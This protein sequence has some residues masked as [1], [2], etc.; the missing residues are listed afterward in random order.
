[1]RN[2]MRAIARLLGLQ[3]QPTDSHAQPTQTAG[4]VHQ[5]PI[6]PR[7]NKRSVATTKP[8]KSP[9]VTKK[10]SSKPKAAQST[11]VGKSRKAAPKSA[12]AVRGQTG[13]QSATPASKTR[14]PVKPAVKAKAVRAPSIKAA[15]LSQQEQA[16]API[17]MEAQSGVRGKPKTTARKTRQH[18]K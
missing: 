9:S 1:M 14:L 17:P 5:E 15:L 11:S 6:Q 10:P 2:I 13:K 8:R 18:A 4:L 7:G 12:P 16:P 3:T